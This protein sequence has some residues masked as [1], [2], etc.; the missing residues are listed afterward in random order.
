MIRLTLNIF[1]HIEGLKIKKKDYRGDVKEKLDVFLWRDDSGEK[2]SVEILSTEQNDVLEKVLREAARYSVSFK[3]AENAGIIIRVPDQ[4]REE[5]ILACLEDVWNL[6]L[7]AGCPGL[8]DDGYVNKARTA[9]RLAFQPADMTLLCR[10]RLEDEGHYVESNARIVVINLE[11]FKWK[12]S[13]L[14]LIEEGD[15]EGKEAHYWY[16]ETGE[17]ER[18][19]RKNAGIK[20]TGEEREKKKTNQKNSVLAGEIELTVGLRKK[21]GLQAFAEGIG[22]GQKKAAVLFLKPIRF[23]EVGVQQVTKILERKVLVDSGKI[24]RMQKGFREYGFTHMHTGARYICNAARIEEKL[25]AAHPNPELIQLNMAQRNLLNIKAPSR[26]ND[27]LVDSLK[28]DTDVKEYI[29]SVYQEDQDEEVLLDYGQKKEVLAK[30]NK[31]GYK[32]ISMYPV[33]ESYG[34]SWK[35]NRLEKIRRWCS[36]KFVGDKTIELKCARPYN[37][38]EGN[39]I[40]R[41]TPDNMMILGIE[42]TDKVIISYGDKETRARVLPYDLGNEWAEITNTNYLLESEKG[43]MEFLVGIPTSIRA[44]LG[45]PGINVNIEVHRDTRYLFK[46]NLNLQFLPLVAMLFTISDYCISYFGNIAMPLWLRVMFPIVLT[47]ILSP[48]AFWFVFSV[49]R[50]KVNTI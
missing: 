25:P 9:T 26:L 48:V 50:N 47:L 30:L 22:G 43:E 15:E 36:G 13:M 1:N 40:V 41:M 20:D 42:P 33:V 27:R 28:K 24:A 34:T 44:E 49:E 21:L 38:D 7:L 12:E 32:N 17:K 2:L 37:I 10:K 6:S 8:F 11:N 5:Q 35:R 39:R 18:L 31:I 45:I 4:T 29:L 23:S 3:K 14:N 19:D 16:G 46:K